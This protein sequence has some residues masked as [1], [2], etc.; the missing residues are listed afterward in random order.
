MDNT[1][2]KALHMMWDKNPV[3]DINFINRYLSVEYKDDKELRKEFINYIGGPDVAVEKAENL[4]KQIFRGQ[5]GGYDFKFKPMNWD[6]LESDGDIFIENIYCTIDPNGEVT[7]MGVDG[8]TY[9]IGQ[10]NKLE[11]NGVV[12]ADMAWE[13]GEETKDVIVETLY[14]EITKKTGVEISGPTDVEVEVSDKEFTTKLD[15]AINR[16]KNLL[17]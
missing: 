7:L 6:I 11:T 13:I 17:L 8:E 2:K 1:F 12:D 9:T 15:E 14:N 16:I 5:S 3:Y 10:I 4:M